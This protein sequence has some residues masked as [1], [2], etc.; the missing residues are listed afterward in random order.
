MRYL[1]AILL[2]MSC[3]DTLIVEDDKQEYSYETVCDCY[4]SS[5]NILGS[6][7]DIRLKYQTYEDYISSSED[8][9]R[10]N[11]LKEDFNELRINCLY[12]FGAHLF[13][14]SDCNYP[15]DL[16]IMVHN[17]FNLGI[18]INAI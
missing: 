6:V 12:S 14:S 13:I 1:I 18:D 10:V 5:T 3:E 15:C 7:I 11:I 16:E 9:E 17:L 2:L 4:S 8:V